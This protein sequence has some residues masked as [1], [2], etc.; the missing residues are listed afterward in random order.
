MCI[1]KKLGIKIKILRKEKKLSQEKLAEIAGL[2]R[3]YI[4]QVERGEKSI[5]I[6][7]L[8]KICKALS[9]KP[10][11]LLK[12]IEDDNEKDFPS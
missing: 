2:H 10:S 6:N 8:I 4:G 11:A 3:N 9:V 12:M 5:T 7:S 1:E